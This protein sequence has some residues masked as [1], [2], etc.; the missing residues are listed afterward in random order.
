MKIFKEIQRFNQWWLVVLELLVLLIVTYNFV[1]EFKLIETEKSD[2]SIYSITFSLFIVLLVIAL[3]H[4]IKLK[5]RIDEMGVAYQFSPF[6]LK[7]KIIPWEDLSKCYVRKYSP[8]T[9][10]GGWGMR[11]ILRKG[12]LNIR[13]K[14]KAFNIKGDV[15]IQLIFNDGGKLLIGTQQSDNANRVIQNYSY[16]ISGNSTDNR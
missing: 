2:K 12:F 3:I 9:E 1:E 15:G 13:G 7:L 4:S 5:T 14:G 16:K 10:Y 11:G 8:I 6:H